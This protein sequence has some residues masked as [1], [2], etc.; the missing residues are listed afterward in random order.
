MPNTKPIYAGETW[1]LVA[2][3]GRADIYLRA[4]R[5]SP[6]SSVES[7]TNEQARAKEHDL[8]SD[9]P[10]RAFDSAGQGRHSMGSD[11]AVK[12]HLREAFAKRVAQA[13]AAGRKA[14]RFSHLVLIAEPAMLGEV[15]AHLDNTTAACVSLT[16]AKDYAG[17]DPVAIAALIDSN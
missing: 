11:H 15:R 3:S 16:I 2:D 9:S 6:L 13:L 10:G 4:R 1:V 14:G 7:L 5:R 8:I 12:H 17:R